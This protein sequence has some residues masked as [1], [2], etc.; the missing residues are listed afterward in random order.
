MSES[1]PPERNALGQFPKGVSGNPAGRPRGA[2]NRITLL[3]QSL[4][5]AMREQAQPRMHNVMK[6][7]L[8][9]AEAG[10]KDM[11]KLLLNLHMSRG[12]A[13][14]K[15]AKDKFEITINS[16]APPHVEQTTVIEALEAD[17]EEVDH[18]KR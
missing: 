3:K 12:S 14:E 4:E 5:L 17:Y 15:E 16:E 1:T 9:L 13:D 2:K 8:N 10:D 18:A 11:I 7:A 6:Q